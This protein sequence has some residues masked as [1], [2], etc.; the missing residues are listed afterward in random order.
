MRLPVVLMATL[1]LG[2]PMADAQQ[3]Q[4]PPPHEAIAAVRALNEEYI[5]AARA[6]D[7]TWF[8]QYM[9][10]DAVVIL[11]T[12]R[13]VRKLEFLALLTSEPKSYRSLTVRDITLRAF[14]PTVQVD[15]DAPWELAN[16]SKGIS[17]YIDT[18]AWLEGRWQVISAQVTL[19]PESGARA[20][21]Y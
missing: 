11:G 18:Y 13:R 19:L 9:A 10:E 14:G 21:R 15:A 7:A 3:S 4:A 20:Q 2:T 17:R 5:D 6:N 1:F 12:G 16:G 8:H